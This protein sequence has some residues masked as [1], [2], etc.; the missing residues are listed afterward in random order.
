M[1]TCLLVPI[2]TICQDYT[3]Y[4]RTHPHTPCFQRVMKLKV[5]SDY[6]TMTHTPVAA[7]VCLFFSVGGGWPVLHFLSGHTN[8][9]RPFVVWP[10]FPSFLCAAN[11]YCQHSPKGSL[12]WVRDKETWKQLSGGRKERKR[13]ASRDIR[14]K[15][16]EVSYFVMNPN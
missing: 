10:W 5:D 13:E 15:R 7:G 12:K 6:N 1:R 9:I 14:D 3:K 4:T 8:C 11:L 16:G 2:R